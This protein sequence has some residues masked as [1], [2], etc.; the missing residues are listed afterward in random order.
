MDKHTLPNAFL[1]LFTWFGA[2][3]IGS[4]LSVAEG[5]ASETAS[6][7]ATLTVRLV[8]ESGAPVPNALVGFTACFGDQ[9][10]Q[11]P[12]WHY[13]PDPGTLEQSPSEVL[14]DRDGVAVFVDGL[15]TIKN[16]RVAIVA[17]Q[18]EQGLIQVFSPDQD[19]EATLTLTMVQECCVAGS[20]AGF[21]HADDPG[22]YAFNILA[23]KMLCIEHYSDQPTFEIFLPPGRFVFQNIG[24]VNGSVSRQFE[25]IVPPHVRRMQLRPVEL[26]ASER[27]RL[28]GKKAPEL[29]EVI[30]WKTNGPQS[31]ADLEGRVVLLDFWGY[32]CAACVSKL[33][34][35]IELQARY[36]HRGFTVVGIHV[37]SGDRIT[38]LE[39]YMEYEDSLKSGILEGQDIPYPI[40]LVADAL[41]PHRRS[42]AMALSKVS[43][44]YGVETY[45]TMMLIDR[46][47]N[48]AGEFH[49]NEHGI[50]FLESLLA[51]AK[52]G[53][54]T[55]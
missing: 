40:V 55:K 4:Q 39:A 22:K 30:A 31:L 50:E 27:Q 5:S 51:A 12:S 36:G 41:R 54:E 53:P 2:L 3:F 21:A 10:F 44:D 18:E 45:P 52:Q 42:G 19:C 23:G 47:G 29:T 28:I 37:D 7:K 48:V 43:R 24:S 14:S 8:D 1:C 38:T 25:L 13:L 26:F 11:N 32:W 35:L 46:H 34:R 49:D 20:F 15:E 6:V 9:T 16:Y 17:R 33:P